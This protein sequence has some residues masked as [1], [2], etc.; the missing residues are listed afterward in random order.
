MSTKNEP[1]R[2]ILFETK[3]HPVPG[4]KISNLAGNAELSNLLTQKK[5]SRIME[6]FQITGLAKTSAAIHFVR[7]LVEAGKEKILVFAHHLEV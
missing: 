6:L 4:E 3:T 5:Q 2:Y 1:S 7:E